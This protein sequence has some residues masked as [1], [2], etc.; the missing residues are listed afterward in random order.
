VRLEHFNPTQ[1]EKWIA[2]FDIPT[3]APVVNG[4]YRYLIMCLICLFIVIVKRIMKYM[5]RMGQKTGTS[6]ALNIVN[7]RENNAA[8]IALTLQ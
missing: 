6:N 1:N 2:D 8:F 7:V 4:R 5:T 3:Y